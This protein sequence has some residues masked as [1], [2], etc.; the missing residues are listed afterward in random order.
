MD[1]ILTLNQLVWAK[2][3]GFPWWP[4]YI[5]RIVSE[6]L[7]EIEYFGEFERNY[8]DSSRLKT[9]S[10]MIPKGLKKTPK[11]LQSYQQA[12]RVQRNESTIGK[13]RDNFFGK[14]R[15]GDCQSGAFKTCTVAN[16]IST[17]YSGQYP[18]N[19]SAEQL[20]NIPAE[21]HSEVLF[22]E[23]QENL[24]LAKIQKKK[25]RKNIK[26]KNS[27][28]GLSFTQKVALKKQKS[29]LSSF[30]AS[31]KIK[32]TDQVFFDDSQPDEM[33]HFKPDCLL[34][35]EPNW[36]SQLETKLNQIANLLTKERP[37]LSELKTQLLNWR[38]AFTDL[39]SRIDLMFDTSIGQVLMEVVDRSALLATQRLVFRELHKMAVETLNIVQERVLFNFF[40]V[41]QLTNLK[42]D[43]A[44]TSVAPN[45]ILPK[46]L[47]EISESH[48]LVK[49]CPQSS[50]CKVTDS[51]ELEN[52]PNVVFSKSCIVDKKDPEFN[53]IPEQTVFKVCKKIAKLFYV[54][55][56]ARLKSKA[57]CE[58]IA[59][60]IELRIRGSSI[61]QA[62]Y[63]Q[64][65]V[66]LFEKLNRKCDRFLAGFKGSSQ[67]SRVFP[68]SDIV[69][70]FLIKK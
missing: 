57:D 23:K 32:N 12:M 53:L 29:V 55:T 61:S 45:F 52:A 44:I 36:L 62:E 28:A 3:I 30:L 59:N 37:S 11:L 1:A 16:D 56:T 19:V 66:F 13:E 6:K 50:N 26:I 51:S 7:F 69:Q 15:E 40:K 41:E 8:L 21:I 24:N 43:L 38:L 63:Q 5:K 47:L 14:K 18:P 35:D 58:Q 65:C 9:F 60:L 46:K 2:L 31:K 48:S 68:I 70:S 64:K 17:N 39:Q 4:A 33:N 10:E 49:R 22:V 20:H 54:K 67:V 42:L 25:I 34:L 27:K